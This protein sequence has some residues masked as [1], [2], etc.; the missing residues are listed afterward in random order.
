MTIWKTGGMRSL[1]IDRAPRGPRRRMVQSPDL[2]MLA[3]HI[4]LMGTA[5]KFGDRWTWHAVAKRIDARERPLKNAL[6]LLVSA[7]VVKSARRGMF[8]DYWLS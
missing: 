6:E 1:A 7:G 3:G 8:R 4:L 5:G 2:D